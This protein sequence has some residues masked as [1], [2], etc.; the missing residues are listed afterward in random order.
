MNRLGYGQDMHTCCSVVIFS[1]FLC[2]AEPEKIQLNS[3]S[4]DMTSKTRAVQTHGSNTLQYL[5]QLK[6][7]TVGCRAAQQSFH[8]QDEQLTAEFISLQTSSEFSIQSSFIYSGFAEKRAVLV[9][10]LIMICI[11]IALLCLDIAMCIFTQL[12]SIIT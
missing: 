2:L 4:M 12:Y 1:T 9:P 10:L 8:L 11:V 5:Q 7:F 3:A 6:G